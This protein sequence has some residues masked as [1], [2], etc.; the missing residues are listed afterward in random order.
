MNTFFM[1]LRWISITT[2]WSFIG[3]PLHSLTTSIGYSLPEVV[4]AHFIMIRHG[5]STTTL[6]TPFYDPS[7]DLYHHL[8]ILHWISSTPPHHFYR[9]FFAGSCGWTLYH[10]PSW[11]LYHHVMNT[12]FMILHRI[13]VA[14]I[15]GLKFV[16]HTWHNW[17]LR[18]CN[19]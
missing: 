1:I 17:C 7:L 14:T 2:L 9:L 4:A 18:L 6:W 16:C 13:Y 19:K 11:D 12:F 15:H 3:S 10:D 5:I 8:M